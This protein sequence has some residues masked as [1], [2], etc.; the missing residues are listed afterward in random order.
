MLELLAL[1]MN[2]GSLAKNYIFANRKC[3]LT[4]LFGPFKGFSM[5]LKTF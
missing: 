3:V 4:G 1:K 5:A 2:I